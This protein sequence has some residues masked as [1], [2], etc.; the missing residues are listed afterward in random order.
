MSGFDSRQQLAAASAGWG[1]RLMVLDGITAEHLPDD[2]AELRQ[3]WENLQAAVAAELEAMA[4]VMRLLSSV[5]SLRDIL[6]DAAEEPEPA[7]A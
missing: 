6:V 3:A 5:A 7:G 4:A 1:V 2:D